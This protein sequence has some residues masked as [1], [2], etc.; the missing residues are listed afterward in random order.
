[1]YENELNALH[2]KDRFRERKL[3]GGYA[4]FASNDYLGFAKDKKQL[5]KA[6]KTLLKQDYFAPRASQ[7]VNGYA[8]IHAKFEKLLCETNGFES[9]ML[10]GSGFAA[11]LSL[12]STLPRRRDLVLMDDEYHASGVMGSE[13]T[14]GKV[15]FFAHNDADAL[16][17]KLQNISGY[18]R[19]FIFV[20]GVYSMI[21]DI[22]ERRIFDIA[23]KYNAV[24]VVDE[25][26]SVGVLGDRLL[27]VFDYYKIKPKPNHIKMGTLGKALGSFG[28][29]VLASMEVISFL[30]NRA[31]PFVYA[32]A[33]SLFDT[34]LAYH[35][36]KKMIKNSHLLKV[37]L[38]ERRFRFCSVTKCDFETQVAMIEDEQNQTKKL[39]NILLEN[40]ILT[41]FIRPP[42][43]S[44]PA[45]RAVI[46][47]SADEL[48]FEKF[49]AIL[50]GSNIKRAF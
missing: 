24:L 14:Q 20:E 16:E 35:N 22:L 34:A 8:P 28:A 29:Y 30:E 32:T 11:N 2:A 39:H 17:A 15:E 36:Y 50:S 5:K 49:L 37:R 7:L 46:G 40:K 25:A 4:D 13:S 18:E 26:H 1:M 42:T 9:A 44:R 48:E 33:L 47:L 3:Y 19:V 38:N 6:Y 21:G 27:G 23:D 10:F 31:K 41:G 45:I 12:V 43:V